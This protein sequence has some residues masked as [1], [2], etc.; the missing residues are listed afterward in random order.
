MIKA[1]V[2]Y[3]QKEKTCKITNDIDCLPPD[4]TGHVKHVFD[5]MFDLG[6]KVAQFESAGYDV[7]VDIDDFT[8]ESP[9]LKDDIIPF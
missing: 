4:I 8:F 9:F 7:I 2:G 1:Y 5:S 6:R 3:N